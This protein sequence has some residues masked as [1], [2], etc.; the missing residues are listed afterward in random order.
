M[1]TARTRA[2]STSVWACA[3]AAR[4]VISRTKPA[5]M[6]RQT[7]AFSPSA[8]G[9]KPAVSLWPA[10]ASAGRDS[11]PAFSR[12]ATRF[13]RH[14][15]LSWSLRPGATPGLHTLES[16][17]KGRIRVEPG[18][19]EDDRIIR[20]LEGRRAAVEV[21]LVPAADVLK[22]PG[23]L[24]GLIAREQFEVPP[25]GALLG[26]GGDEQLHIGK[27]AHDSSDVAPVQDRARGLAGELALE[28]QE[29]V[30]HGL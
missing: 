24:R 5:A 30:P 18:G 4:S 29:G 17:A 7:I 27:R 9:Q 15:R 26:R 25:P 10:P 22:D 21:P 6:W 16:S 2:R 8:L 14:K 28:I 12:S 13:P 1:S 20:R 19:V 23:E 11:V 3:G